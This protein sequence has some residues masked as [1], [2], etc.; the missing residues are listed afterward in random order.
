MGTTGE[1]L[2]KI[3]DTKS[4]IKD[5]II[6][7]GVSISD[8]DTFASYATK[9]SSI[10]G[11]GSGTTINMSDKTVHFSID[12]FYRALSD[13]TV[14]ADTYT[15]IFDNT[16]F[17]TLKSLHDTY[18]AIII[19]N[20]INYGY[21]GSNE[22]KIENVSTKYKEEL[23][24]NDWL[25]FSYHQNYNETYDNTTEAS[26][27]LGYYQKCHNAV[28]TWGN[29]CNW[30]YTTRLASYTGND[31]IISTLANEGVLVIL[32]SDDNRV[33]YGLTTTDNNYLIN[34]GYYYKNNCLYVRTHLRYENT[35][36]SGDN[37]TNISNAVLFTH[38]D[39]LQSQLANIQTSFTWFN[40]NGYEFGDLQSLGEFI[41]TVN[42]NA[43]NIKGNDPD[44]PEAT[45][46]TITNNL[47]NCTSNNTTTSISANSRYTATLTADD[48]YTLDTPTIIMGGT[49]VTSTV[50]SNGTITI[51]A[52]TGDIIITCSAS[53]SGGETE[54]INY[55]KDIILDGSCYFNTGI[56]PEATINIEAKF[57]STTG[58]QNCICGCAT[59]IETNS[60]T[61]VV[62]MRVN[63]S[64]YQFMRG[65]NKADAVNLSTKA[66][67]DG[68]YLGS[69]SSDGTYGMP[70]ELDLYIGALNVAGTSQSYVCKSGT[71]ICYVKITINDVTVGDF[72]AALDNEGNP[73]L[74][75]KISKQFIYN[76]GTGTLTYTA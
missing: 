21:N 60:T 59:V 31:S 22:Y 55:V 34:N 52:V 70:S 64:N 27:V 5:A 62:M 43:S 50:Y 41:A 42:G 28:L 75:D 3:L 46:Y 23:A 13:I 11:S 32:S 67:D 18:G 1:K 63:W 12:D 19:C 48:G 36:F 58:V 47:T 61:Q 40:D 37:F 30:S 25:K 9:I 49:D 29:A 16:T 8:S 74:Y 7:K 45:E 56:K 72:N 69:G 15:S 26:T 17:S 66:T 39:Y 68:Y 14:N 2:Q 33:S 4:A 6:A 24:K 10:S 53:V 71:K 44:T 20:C 54:T 38:E 65:Y 35:A 76:I 51:N 73:C 57:Y